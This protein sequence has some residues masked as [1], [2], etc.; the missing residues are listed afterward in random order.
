MHISGVDTVP[1]VVGDRG[2]GGRLAQHG[3][4]AGGRCLVVLCEHPTLV[5]ALV[6]QLGL[7]DHQLLFTAELEAGLGP[8]VQ[9]LLILQPD[10]PQTSL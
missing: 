4:E 2:D 1:D 3:Q 7:E 8:R 10:S 5:P 9:R 6:L